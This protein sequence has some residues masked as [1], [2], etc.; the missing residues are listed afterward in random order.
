MVVKY[1]LVFLLL[2][3]VAHAHNED[4]PGPNGGHIKMPSSYHTELVL[5]EGALEIY[6]LDVNFKNPMVKNS[7]LEVYYIKNKKQEKLKCSSSESFYRCDFKKD[8]ETGELLLKSKR[9]GIKGK[10]V[11]YQL[12]LKFT[13][14]KKEE[15]DSHANHH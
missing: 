4:K 5:K 2:S 9:N 7:Q 3:L 14:V 12:P 8:L 10:D 15:T 1:F 6:L 11:S 13:S